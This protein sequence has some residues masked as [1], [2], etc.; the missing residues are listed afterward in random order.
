[1]HLKKPLGGTTNLHFQPNLTY[2]QS[3][4]YHTNRLY[5]PGRKRSW[6]TM[7]PIKKRLHQVQQGGPSMRVRW[8]EPNQTERTG[9]NKQNANKKVRK[10]EPKVHQKQQSQEKGTT[11]QRKKRV[12]RHQFKPCSRHQG[13]A[14]WVRHGRCTLWLWLAFVLPLT[15]AWFALSLAGTLVPTLVA[16]DT[17]RKNLMCLWEITSRSRQ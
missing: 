2:Y 13:S 9:S 7:F 17:I 4:N 11:K 6:Q 3:S 10:V 12:K 8:E 15:L 5:W 16:T 14:L 1:M